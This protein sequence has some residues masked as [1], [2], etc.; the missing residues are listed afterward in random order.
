[1]HTVALDGRRADLCTEADVEI[2]HVIVQRLPLNGDVAAQSVPYAERDRF[3]LVAA[4][5][6]VSFIERSEESDRFIGAGA[7]EFPLAPVQ[8][9]SR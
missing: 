4:D 1:M 7:G 6:I 9:E 3:V 2:R 8:P 5:E